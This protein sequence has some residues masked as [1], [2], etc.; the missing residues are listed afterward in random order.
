MPVIRASERRYNRT[1][2]HSEVNS[3]RRVLN[4][5][6]VGEEASYTSPV[7]NVKAR[8]SDSSRKARKLSSPVLAASS[9]THRMARPDSDTGSL[10]DVLH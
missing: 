1:I 9:V 3:V 8:T 6:H 10:F 4:K 7:A 5:I 2:A